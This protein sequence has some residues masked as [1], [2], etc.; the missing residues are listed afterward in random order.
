[1]NATLVNAVGKLLVMVNVSVL[2][3]PVVMF[4]GAKLFEM[5][6]LAATINV[7]EAVLPVP[8]FVALT[9]P[10]TLA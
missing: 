10:D 7:A 3:A 1:M 4:E 5:V 9:A 2:L 8:P 6:G